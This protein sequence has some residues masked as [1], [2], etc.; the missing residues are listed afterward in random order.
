MIRR[1]LRSITLVA[2]VAAPAAAGPET[3]TKTPSYQGT[4]A[5]API[6]AA[7]H[8]RNTG[9]SDGAGLCVIAS[10]VANGRYVGVP[11]LAELWAAARDRPG[12]YSPLKFQLLVNE[13]LP[14][15]KW[16]SYEGRDP[17]ILDRLSRQGYAIGATMNTGE[18]YG[19]RRI[20]HMVSL[21]HFDWDADLAC[22]VDNNEPGVYTWMKAREFVRRWIDGPEGWALVWK[23]RPGLLMFARYLPLI[24]P[25]IYCAACVIAVALVLPEFRSPEA[26]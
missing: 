16:A 12:G 11:E 8:Q 22:V 9:G 3:H 4:T 13:I 7:M 2:L 23:R 25:T 10:M 20:H 1:F 6:P 15:E 19:Y 5:R 17:M 18:L 14:G 26:E 24:P 21:V